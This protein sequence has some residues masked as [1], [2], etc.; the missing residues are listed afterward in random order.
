MLG[1]R[2]IVNCDTNGYL[3]WSL[4]FDSP[5]AGYCDTDTDK[6]FSVAREFVKALNRLQE[7]GDIP[8]DKVNIKTVRKTLANVSLQLSSLHGMIVA[9][10]AAPDETIS[11]DNSEWVEK[12]TEAD[13]IL[14]KLEQGNFGSDNDV[15]K[16]TKEEQINLKADLL[17]FIHLVVIGNF[18]EPEYI[19]AFIPAVELADK[20][21]RC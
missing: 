2:L 20:L 6:I 15:S 12:L 17:Q 13:G 18:Y 9:D 8:A 7:Q 19:K 3:T 16:M 10:G 1:Y 21:S 4:L 11:I 5:T 14:D